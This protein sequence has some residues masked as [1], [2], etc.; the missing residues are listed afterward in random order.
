MAEPPIDRYS[1]LHMNSIPGATIHMQISVTSYTFNSRKD[2]LFD[3]VS[4]FYPLDSNL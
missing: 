2:C 1:L 4:D 3:H